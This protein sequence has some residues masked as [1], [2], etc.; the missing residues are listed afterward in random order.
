M[1]NIVLTDDHVLLRKGLAALIKSLGHNVLFEANDG[2][3]FIAKLQPGNLPDL[4]LLD[5]NMPE[6]DGVETAIWIKE[7]HP[8][9]KVLAVSMYDNE[10]SII[11]ML[12]AG[13]R[14]YILKDS[15]PEELDNA[16]RSILTK[17]F[18]YSELISGKLVH[19]ISNVEKEKT[20]IS[21]LI[22]LNEKETEFLKYTC[23][24]LT[25]KEI[26]D[27][28]STSPRTVDYYRDTLLEK[29]NVKTRIGLA[30]YAIKNGIVRL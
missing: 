1:A 21:T 18:Y 12:K 3:D 5:I 13:A 30:M 23:T 25:Y 17:D 20:E 11:R 29:L 28:M 14:G 6:K 2:N 26:A 27:K 9:V 8:T 19:A 7:N 10:S 4:V 24:E 15:E 16:I 22:T